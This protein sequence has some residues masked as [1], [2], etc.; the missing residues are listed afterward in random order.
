MSGNT[1]TST[2]TIKSLTQDDEAFLWEMLY[3]ALYVPT[4]HA[5]FP[6]EIVSQPELAKYVLEWGKKDDLGFAAVSKITFDPVGAVWIRLFTADIKGYGYVSDQ[7]PELSIAILPG[8]RNQGIGTALLKHLIEEVKQK[9]PG[10]SLSVSSCNPVIQLYRRMGFEVITESE[11]SLTMVK[12]F[13][14]S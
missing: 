14:R 6:K 5:P 1:D 11:T 12:N 9:Y 7:I 8:Y 3:H 10:L 13:D 2:Y 4:G